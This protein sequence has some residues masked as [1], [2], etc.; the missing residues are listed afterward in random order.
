MKDIHLGRDSKIP[1]SYDPS[2]LSALSR[3]DSRINLGLEDLSVVF[4]GHDFW[5]SYETSWLNL[6]GVPSNGILN[7]SYDCNSK[8][9]IESKSLKLYLY[10]LNNEK[11]ESIDALEKI[12]K[13]DL[14]GALKTDVN[15]HLDETPRE[16]FNRPLSLDSMA[17]TKIDS[18]PNSLVIE[19]DE[20]KGFVS[21]HISTSL[22]RSLCPVTAQPDWATVYISYKG[23]AIKHEGILRYLLSYRN[24]QGFHE[25]CVERIYVDIMKR[26]RLDELSV[27]ANFLRRGGIEINPVRTTPGYE[28]SINREIRQ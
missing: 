16:I 14:E 1:T 20:D 9:F 21:E 4:H 18:Y 5:T 24:H 26:C 22:F 11:F 28:I 8:F 6:Q 25:Q 7:I 2:S 15:V 3:I 27:T 17:I 23:T 13:I 10:S 12:I 19:P